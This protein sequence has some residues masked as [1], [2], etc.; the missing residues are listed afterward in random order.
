VAELTEIAEA[1]RLVLER[2]VPLG[3]EP[4]PL[5]ETLG[6]VLAEDVVSAEA[7]PGFD[8]SAMDGYAIRAVDA[9][10]VAGDR[11][12]V[13]NLAGESRAGHPAG[14]V[15]AAGEAIAISTGAMI[16]EGA[17]AVVRIEDTDRR[18][19]E[20]EVRVPVPEGDNIRRT[21]EDIEAGTRVLGPG[22]LIGAAEIGVISSSPRAEVAC[23]RVPSVRVVATG[24]ELIGPSEPMRP[25][26]VRDSNAHTVPALALGAGAEVASVERVGDDASAT[27]TVLGRALEANV[28]VVCGGV[29]VGEHDHVRPALA[30]LG[31]EQVFWGVSLRPG[32]PTWF[33][34]APGGGLIFGL[35][36]N[37][38][39]AMVTFILFARP[40]LLAMQG[41][42]PEAP[43]ATA[44]L[45]SAYP[46]K[47][48][49]AHA[50]RCVL[51]AGPDGLTART[52][53]AQG[54]HILTSM[55]GADAL[56]MIPGDSDGVAAG[57]RVD[58]ELLPGSRM[59]GWR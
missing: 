50:V 49:R 1:R 15:L 56:A 59:G 5:A 54:S 40:A 31:A 38:V 6:R 20:V 37:P 16:P 26:G 9:E 18:D 32:K 57:E 41:L 8:N 3:T 47:R 36:G 45:E 14:R 29:S 35:P 10:G 53:G 43:R 2:V 17:D 24:D 51:R 34:V 39:S 48:G 21:G 55:L 13:L 46:R 44:V 58:V 25:G 42:D 27:R 23:A 4:V 7:V 11:P 28:A 12:A 52:T 22:Q 19:G 33:G 30:K